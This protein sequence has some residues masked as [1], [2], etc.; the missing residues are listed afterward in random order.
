MSSDPT[1][2]DEGDDL[3]SLFTEWCADNEASELSCSE[4]LSAS[5]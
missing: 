1:S 5:L 4:R 3:V 2:L